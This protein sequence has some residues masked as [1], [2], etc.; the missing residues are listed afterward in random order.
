MLAELDA[1]NALVAAYTTG[2]NGLVSQRRNGV[3][4]FHH[5]D[6]L[7]S[8]RQLT[9]SNQ[10]ITDTYSF[11]AYGNITSQGGSSINPAKY[12]GSQ[13]YYGDGDSGL[14]LLG[15][16]YYDP[17]VGHFITLDPVKQGINWYVYCANNPVNHTDPTGLITPNDAGPCLGFTL[18]GGFAGIMAFVCPVFGIVWGT[19]AI[20]CGVG[21]GI[22]GIYPPST[23]PS[24]QPPNG[25]GAFYQPPG[26]FVQP[27]LWASPPVV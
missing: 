3:S 9:D 21:A 19:V 18:A 8:T 4:R 22:T 11:D 26:G 25:G 17:A 23:W 14:M 5:F 13:G 20:V 7:G 2:T 27:H 15:H 16:R 12:V 10:T 24:S 6:G 1:T